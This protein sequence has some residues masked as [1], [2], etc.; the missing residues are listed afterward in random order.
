MQGGNKRIAFALAGEAAE[1]LGGDDN[2]LLTAVHGDMLRSFDFGAPH[3]LAEAS[4]CVLQR[5][6]TP[7]PLRSIGFRLS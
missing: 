3:K 4:L 2:H 7:S 5:P 6:Q 1:L